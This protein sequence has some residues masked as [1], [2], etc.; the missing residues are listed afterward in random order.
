MY[1]QQTSIKQFMP[2]S[3]IIKY[4]HAQTQRIDAYHGYPKYYILN[5]IPSHILHK[6][7]FKL[8]LIKALTKVVTY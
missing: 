4:I 1:C 2:K 3:N 5:Y 8:E 6:M 7:I